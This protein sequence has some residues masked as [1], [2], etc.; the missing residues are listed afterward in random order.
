MLR[1]LANENVPFD[2][3][4]ALRTDGHDVTWIREVT[5]GSS[6]SDVLALAERELRMLLTFD[7]D[8]GELA[9]RGPFSAKCGIVL[10]RLRPTSPAALARRVKVALSS[11]SDWT[12]HFSVIEDGRIR[13]T[14]IPGRS[15]VP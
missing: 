8:F 3:I 4:E 13:M 1:I 6:D 10:A 2:V 7:K 14:P 12:G 11:R 9:F 15:G 5:P